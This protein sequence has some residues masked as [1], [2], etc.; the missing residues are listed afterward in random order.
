LVIKTP[1]S[2]LSQ[3]K[4]ISIWNKLYATKNN[5]IYTFE[6]YG[7]INAGGINAINKA[8][9]KLSSI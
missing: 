5:K 8:C 1:G 2:D 3:Y 7:L 4:S 6:Y 9:Q